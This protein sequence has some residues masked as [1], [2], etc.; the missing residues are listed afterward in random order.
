MSALTTKESSRTYTG[1]RG[2]F[3]INPRTGRATCVHYPRLSPSTHPLSP[4]PLLRLHHNFGTGAFAVGRN[5]IAIFF[6]AATGTTDLSPAIVISTERRMDMP[7]L[8][9]AAFYRR[10]GDASLRLS[11]LSR[12]RF[13]SL[14][15]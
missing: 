8:I 2:S 13:I 14:H 6:A 3:L 10:R 12:V 5:F 11:T 7:R 4:A 1:N 9:A 15:A